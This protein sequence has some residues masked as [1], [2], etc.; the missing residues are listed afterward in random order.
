MIHLAQFC[1]GHIAWSGPDT[2]SLSQNL[3]E[4]HFYRTS[5]SLRL[6]ICPGAHCGDGNVESF[7]GLGLVGSRFVIVREGEA[8]LF[9]TGHQQTPLTACNIKAVRFP[10]K[11][12]TKGKKNL[13]AHWGWLIGT[14]WPAFLTSTSLKLPP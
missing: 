4:S 1:Q 12:D 11:K 14:E 7:Y 13:R 9:T 5:N 10:K 3:S 2:D 8:I 6:S